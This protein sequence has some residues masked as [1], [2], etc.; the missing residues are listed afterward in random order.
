MHNAVVW[1]KQRVLDVS[2]TNRGST[3]AGFERKAATVVVDTRG[4]KRE[5]ESG[6]D[7]RKKALA[8]GA[9][10]QPRTNNM[11]VRAKTGPSEVGGPMDGWTLEEVCGQVGAGCGPGCRPHQDRMDGLEGLSGYL[12]AIPSLSHGTRGE[13]R[14]RRGPSRQPQRRVACRFGDWWREPSPSGCV[15]WCSSSSSSSSNSSS[16]AA[17]RIQYVGS[18]SPHP[19]CHTPVGQHRR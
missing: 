1:R 3:G 6:K 15:V 16:A 17:P 9:P 8:R 4:N 12:W 7:K 5:D 11:Q 14:A 18:P 13:A 19:A 2:G 10:G